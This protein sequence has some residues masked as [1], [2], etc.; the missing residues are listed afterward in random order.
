[1]HSL[2][3]VVFSHNIVLVDPITEFDSFE[4]MFS[5]LFDMILVV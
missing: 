2:E 4:A 1:M 3:I 5:L